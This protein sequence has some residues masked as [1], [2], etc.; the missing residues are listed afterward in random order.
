MSEKIKIQFVSSIV[1]KIKIIRDRV[2]K[3]LNKKKLYYTYTKITE[4]S[5]MDLFSNMLSLYY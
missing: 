2:K 1:D 3:T 4:E 5:H